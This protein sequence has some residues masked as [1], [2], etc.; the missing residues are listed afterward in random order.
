MKN[1]KQ[2]E[3]TFLDKYVNHGVH[4]EGYVVRV[5]LA[6]DDNSPQSMYHSATVFV[7]MNIND[8]EG[9]NGADLGLSLNEEAL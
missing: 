9:V 5:L 2:A 7:K 6:E 3:R 4:W 1:K 8:Q